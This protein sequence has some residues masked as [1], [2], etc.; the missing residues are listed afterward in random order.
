M[1]AHA[2]AHSPIQKCRPCQHRVRSL[3]PPTPSPYCST[4]LRTAKTE[5]EP[6]RECGVLPGHPVFP[7]ATGPVVQWD[8][9]RTRPP[10]RGLPEPR[11][12]LGRPRGVAP[13]PVSPL[14]GHSWTL[15]AQNPEQEDPATWLHG[16]E[17][18]GT[19]SCL[20]SAVWTQSSRTSI[21]QGGRE[22][23]RDRTD[24]E[25]DPRTRCPLPSNSPDKP[26]SVLEGHLEA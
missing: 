6:Q 19:S 25:E 21:P 3:Q 10:F 24:E 16:T 8:R 23:G 14:Q 5:L 12:E 1:C 18:R 20:R 4:P 15:G 22:A 7:G 11:P 13:L 9:T 26:P 17:A 2:E